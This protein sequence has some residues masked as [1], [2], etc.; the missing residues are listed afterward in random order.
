ML[1]AELPRLCAG[2]ADIYPMGN[3]L[4]NIIGQDVSGLGEELPLSRQLT[5]ELAQ[6]ISPVAVP[7][8][9]MH[10]CGIWSAGPD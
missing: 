7:L 4:F 8:G 1:M 3:F 6:K 10:D 9:R 2:Q 5:R